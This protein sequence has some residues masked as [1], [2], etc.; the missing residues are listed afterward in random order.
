MIDSTTRELLA[1]EAESPYAA[2]VMPEHLRGMLEI[3]RDALRSPQRIT[4]G[5]D[6]GRMVLLHLALLALDRQAVGALEGQYPAN[7]PALL[8][9]I[10]RLTRPVR[11]MV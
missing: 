4:D 8:A 2:E 10:V 7:V 6:L 1:R 3:A 11:R 9:L 5:N